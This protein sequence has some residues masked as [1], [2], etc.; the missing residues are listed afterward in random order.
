MAIR[1]LRDVFLQDL[2]S[3]EPDNAGLLHSVWPS[4]SKAFTKSL[5]DEVAGWLLMRNAGLT[6]EQTLLIQIT[7]GTETAVGKVEKAL[8]LTLGQNEKVSSPAK[9]NHMRG[10]WT[11]NRA[12]FADDEA[13]YE[14]EDAYNDD[15]YTLP[16][17]VMVT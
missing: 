7:V 3:N 17:M 8:Y 13:C 2:Q 1:S 11:S 12:H 4:P 15:E 6:K 5:P 14:N 16:T 10:R 9:F